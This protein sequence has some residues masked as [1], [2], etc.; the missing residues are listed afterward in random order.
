VKAEKGSIWELSDKIGWS[1]YFR[2][3]TKAPEYRLK[4]PECNPQS[5]VPLKKA[6]ES[7]AESAADKK[8]REEAEAEAKAKEEAEA[9]EK[10]QSGKELSKDEMLDF[11]RKNG[12]NV[13]GNIGEEKLKARYDA[14][15]K[16]E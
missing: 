15:V 12:E 13:P 7:K 3:S 10:E 5:V 16:G 8:A 11:L 9:L 1:P 2:T 14:F 6:E 4:C